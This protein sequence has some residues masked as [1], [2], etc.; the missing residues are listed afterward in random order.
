M[1]Y[2]KARGVIDISK[3]LVFNWETIDRKLN[4]Y[5]TIVSF[6]ATYNFS[7]FSYL[8]ILF[9]ISILGSTNNL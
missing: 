7:T 8:L 6:T 4:Y 9:W 5:C 1:V 2:G 3:L